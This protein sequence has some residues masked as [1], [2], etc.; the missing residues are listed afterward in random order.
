MRW[1]IDTLHA[2]CNSLLTTVYKYAL[3]VGARLALS[4]DVATACICMWS[5]VEQAAYVDHVMSVVKHAQE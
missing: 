5:H 2:I 1:V 3:E 4:F